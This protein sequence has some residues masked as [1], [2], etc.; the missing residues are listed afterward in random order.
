MCGVLLGVV[1]GFGLVGG[2]VG[3]EPPHQLAAGEHHA[4]T[5]ALALQADIRAEADD[6]PLVGAAG[7]GLSQAQ[8]IVE[9]QVGKHERIIPSSSKR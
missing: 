4:P 3:L 8:V 7:M 2:E 6:G 5:A 1:I 9:L